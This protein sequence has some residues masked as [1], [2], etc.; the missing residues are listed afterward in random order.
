MS[1]R[2]GI[3]IIRKA[4]EQNQRD[5]LFKMWLVKYEHMTKDTFISFDKWYA[6]IK[7]EQNNRNKLAKQS[8]EDILNTVAKI[9]AKV[10]EKNEHI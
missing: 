1:V 5:D 2:H 7:K 4:Y 3:E 9:R 6:D 10:V 8:K